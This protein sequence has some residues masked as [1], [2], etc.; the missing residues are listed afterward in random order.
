MPRGDCYLHL[1]TNASVRYGSGQALLGPGTS[2]RNV[3]TGQLVACA[4]GIRVEWYLAVGEDAVFVRL[5]VVDHALRALSQHVCST[6][7]IE[8]SKTHGTSSTVCSTVCADASLVPSVCTLS[9]YPVQYCVGSTV[10]AYASSVPHTLSQYR[11]CR[12]SL[13]TVCAY[14]SSVLRLRALSQYRVRVRV[15]VQY[16]DS[17]RYNP[18][19][20]Y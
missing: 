4:C 6:D 14:A 19:T 16:W 5:E 3:S 7:S 9:Q 12:H 17:V 10:W 2:I 13:I 18:L 11:V 15:H 8:H 1:R 20:W